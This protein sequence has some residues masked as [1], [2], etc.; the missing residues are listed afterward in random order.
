MFRMRAASLLLLLLLVA[1]CSQS[2]PAPP[3]PEASPTPTPPP[4]PAATVVATASSV[5]PAASVTPAPPTETPAPPPPTEEPETLD[6]FEAALLTALSEPDAAALEEMI[7]DSFALG[8]WR[9][10]GSQLA[11]AEAIRTLL[12][13][14][15]ADGGPIVALE[16]ENLPALLDGQEPEALFGPEAG[17]VRVLRSG[18]W[19]VTGEGEGL[20][21]IVEADGG[22]QWYGMIYAGEG[23]IPLPTPELSAADQA[24]EAEL[25]LA[26]ASRD[27]PRLEQLMAEPFV[28]A[29]WRSEARLL[30]PTVATA[31]LRSLHLASG[32]PVA[33]VEEPD[34]AQ[35]TAAINA[36]ALWGEGATVAGV[37]RGFGWGADGSEQ[38]VII[39]G[40]LPDGRA[41]W[42]AMITQ[43]E[44]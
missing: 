3:T 7:G 32:A 17:V 38:A 10:E 18:G 2:A 28:I 43:P 42:L 34:P 14:Y 15:L 1:G 8:F 24:F 9:S 33:L 25:A 35:Y 19:G 36:A 13:Q 37:R 11:R 4:V 22:F 12:D 16:S 41:V 29:P 30:A 6:S 5:P 44:S 40:R 26:L 23:F 20:L 39:L 21:A 27:Y 31:E